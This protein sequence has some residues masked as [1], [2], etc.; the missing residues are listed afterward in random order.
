MIV[1]FDPLDATKKAELAAKAA[2]KG[3]EVKEL[4]ERECQLRHTGKFT[5]NQ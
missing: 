5:L 4:S 3:V 1:S 2:E